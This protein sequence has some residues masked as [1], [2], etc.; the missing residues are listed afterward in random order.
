M[1]E[2]LYCLWPIVKLQYTHKLNFGLAPLMGSK[3]N[4]E[5]TKQ[6]DGFWPCTHLLN[7]YYQICMQFL[8][9]CQSIIVRI[10]NIELDTF[11]P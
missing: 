11:I 2:K 4:W 7:F 9:T 10:E 8:E 3:N 1:Y 5:G 6:E